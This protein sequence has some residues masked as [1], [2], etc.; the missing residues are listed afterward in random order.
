MYYGYTQYGSVAG[1]FWSR[2]W[3]LISS[4]ALS[5]ALLLAGYRFYLARRFVAVHKNGIRLRLGVLRVRA[6]YWAE[7]AGI[8]SGITQ[9]RFLHL[10]LR[11]YS[12]AT[13]YPVKGKPVQLRGPIQDMPALVQC[14]KD[15]LYPRLLPRKRAAYRAGKSLPFGP[16]IL[17]HQGLGLRTGKSASSSG[18]PVLIPWKGVDKI[19]VQSGC[20]SFH[21]R[22]QR[23]RRYPISDIPNFEI[24]LELIQQEVQV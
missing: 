18:K 22:N 11:T 9:E 1:D 13:L 2:P 20:L 24:L 3:L 4:L 10:P 17:H 14:I 7:L 5:V 6:W 12:R 21:T 16:L 15:N 23:P 8:S 19:E